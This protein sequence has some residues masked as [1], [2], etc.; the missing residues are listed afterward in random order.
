MESLREQNPLS[1]EQI[2]QEWI[3][4]LIDTGHVRKENIN[5]KLLTQAI[6]ELELKAY[7]N[8]GRKLH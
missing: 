8:A 7:I 5:W 2:F 3:E 4:Y 1:L 6:T